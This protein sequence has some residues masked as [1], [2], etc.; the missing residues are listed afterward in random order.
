MN[1]SISRWQLT[2][3][4]ISFT[5]G[6]SLLMAPNITAAAADQ[7]GWISMLLATF[8]G[9]LL[10]LLM[11]KLLSMYNY[12]SVYD[13]YDRILGK[14]GGAFFSFLFMFIT[15]HLAALVMRNYSNFM[16]SVAIPEINSDVFVVMMMILV[17]FSA[18]K[19]LQNLA[20]ISQLFAPFLIIL[21]SLALLLVSNNFKL[22]NVTP[23]TDESWKSIM[24]GAYPII[25][26]P[27]IEMLVFTA[28]L[29]FITNKTKIYRF[30]LIGTAVGGVLLSIAI[31]VTIGV[32]GPS[33]V[34]REV[35]AAYSMARSIQLGII[36]QRLEAVIGI[37]WIVALFVK[38]TV[39]FLAIQFGLS[40]YTKGADY[41]RYVLPV[42]ILVWTMSEHLHPDLVDFTDFVAIN[43][44]LYWLTAYVIFITIL[45]V[46]ILFKK[47][48][49][50]P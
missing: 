44:T 31:F 46:G 41:T 43:W 16:I 13:I 5:V 11:L 36:L 4:V 19:G 35:Y 3:I 39:C 42:A 21:I 29:S 28:L 48:K 30:Y 2:A 14:I 47:H 38:I 27:F 49:S 40:H 37:L 9:L 17:I 12:A 34:D 22:E 15:L 24:E 25:G 1:H 45:G 18:S 6:S 8:V 26:F 7:D 10:N 23:V 32:E 33:V 20:R 50:M